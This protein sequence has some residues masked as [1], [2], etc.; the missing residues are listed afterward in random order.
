MTGIRK[1]T[2]APVSIS[3]HN[4]GIFKLKKVVAEWLEGYFLAS[5]YGS[6][7]GQ[8]H[9]AGLPYELLAPLVRWLVLDTADRTAAANSED[10]TAA[11]LRGAFPMD[12]R[13]YNEVALN[14]GNAN[15]AALILGVLAAAC[16]WSQPAAAAAASTPPA[17]ALAT[18]H[19]LDACGHVLLEQPSPPWKW[20]LPQ[21]AL[22]LMLATFK[23]T[24]SFN[25]R[26]EPWMEL[27]GPGVVS[28][29]QC[30][31][32]EGVEAAVAAEAAAGKHVDVVKL[33][34]WLDPLLYR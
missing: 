14:V 25:T 4:A 32:V 15:T 27:L 29:L 2:N 17:S 34:E 7:M 5:C 20:S 3:L 10:L 9:T 8:P 1:A 28:L 22:L 30:K 19:K 13:G 18:Q 6:T 33:M 23:P 31:L 16:A 24:V 11:A 12:S 21:T 26:A